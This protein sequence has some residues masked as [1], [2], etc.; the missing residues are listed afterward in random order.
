MQRVVQVH[1]LPELIPANR[2][3]GGVAVVIDVLRATTTI[4][5]ALAAGCTQVVP[6]AT[7]DEAKKIADQMLAGK[8]LLGGERGGLP[9]PGFDLG[10]SPGDYVPAVCRGA[11]V[12]F[13]TTNGTKALLRATQASRVLVAA[14]TNFSAVCEHIQRE[15]RPLHI[16]CAGQAG[17]VALEDAILAGAFIEFLCEQTDVALN[18][19]AR[20][21]WDTFEN[22]G[23]LLQGALELSQGGSHLKSLGLEKDIQVAAEI[24]RFALVPALRSDTTRI[25]LLSAGV[26]G[27]H[28]RK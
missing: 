4:V 3:Q 2:L 10:N 11:T 27:S 28:W 24:D 12:V 22:H 19:G 20:I 25:E 14:F 18:D 26:V 5:H 16:I 1:L 6:A 8:V 23:Q 17:E 7:T 15:R 21:A 13:T 9:P